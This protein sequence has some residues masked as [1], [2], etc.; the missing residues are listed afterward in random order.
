MVNNKKLVNNGGTE[1]G[2]VALREGA[3]IGLV[4]MIHRLMVVPQLHTEK[5]TTAV[6]L[7]RSSE[8]ARR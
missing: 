7:S 5:T 6:K 1:V 2:E 8:H 3:I 4:E